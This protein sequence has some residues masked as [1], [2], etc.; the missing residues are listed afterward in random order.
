M[1]TDNNGTIC[2]SCNYLVDSYEFVPWG[3]ELAKVCLD[4]YLNV[5]GEN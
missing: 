3:E 4:C 1:I 2:D 5:M